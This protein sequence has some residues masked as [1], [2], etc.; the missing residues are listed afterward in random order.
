M[1]TST[2]VAT[3]RLGLKES[4]DMTQPSALPE[5]VWQTLLGHAFAL[6]DETD[7]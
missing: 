6:V 5:G 4:T 7:F 3:R 2:A 1:G